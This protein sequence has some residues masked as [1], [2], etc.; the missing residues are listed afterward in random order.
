MTTH[1]STYKTCSRCGKSKRLSEF[2]PGNGANGRANYCKLCRT[3]YLA[4]RRHAR[5][6][7]LNSLF[8]A[9][10]SALRAV[11]AGEATNHYVESMRAPLQNLGELP[12]TQGDHGDHNL[13]PAPPK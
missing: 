13:R 11:D 1:L 12:T 9:V 3:E 4:E 2:S 7:A 5:R 8:D 10:R 6:V